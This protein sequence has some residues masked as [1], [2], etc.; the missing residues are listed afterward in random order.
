MKKYFVLLPLLILFVGCASTPDVT[1]DDQM[2]MMVEEYPLKGSV[3]IIDDEVEDLVKISDFHA[4]RAGS[5]QKVSVQVENI[6]E[7]D[8]VL[9]YAVRIRVN[10]Q[11]VDSPN[12]AWA[13]LNIQRRNYKVISFVI[14]SPQFSSFEL[15]LK[16]GGEL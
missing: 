16:L 13:P 9:E 1:L 15:L 14:P 12:S 3:R 11:E 2:K 8:I 7:D 6:T 4:A 5:N 10:G